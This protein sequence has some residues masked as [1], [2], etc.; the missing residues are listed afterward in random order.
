MKN[1][2]ARRKAI[3]ILMEEGLFQ[4]AEEAL[5]YFLGGQVYCGQVRITSPA[6]LVTCDKPMTV[7]GRELPFVAKGGLKLQG[8]MQDF[9]IS[10][11]DR[12]CIDAGAC[13]GGFTDCL[14]KS[15]AA[16]VYAVEVG[17]GQ[18]AGSLRQNPKVV[19]LEKTNLSDEKLLSLSPRPDLASVDLSYLSLRKAVPVFANIMGY[20]GELMCLVKP[21]FEVEDAAARRT[22][23]LSG[24]VYLPLLLSLIRDLNGLLKVCVVNV[25]NSPV[26]GNQG[27]LEFFLHVKLGVQAADIDL[28][29]AAAEAVQ[30]VLKLDSYRKA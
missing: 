15:G 29:E 12:I 18:L 13:T 2:T 27:T 5:P 11:K 7:K 17:F 25:T 6:Q 30:R 8:A 21:L 1:K 28:G 9:G 22:G 19:N 20:V 10:A 14:V 3:D 23:I 26:T 4:T 16:L 24:D